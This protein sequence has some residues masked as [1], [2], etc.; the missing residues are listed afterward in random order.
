MMY[1]L[2]PTL[3][4]KDAIS[5]TNNKKKGG[6]DNLAPLSFLKSKIKEESQNSQLMDQEHPYSEK[7]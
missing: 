1:L 6:K 3:D 2:A 4:Q 7:Y 5:L